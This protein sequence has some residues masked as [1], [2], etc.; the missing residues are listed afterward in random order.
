ME[1][2]KRKIWKARTLCGRPRVMQKQSVFGKELDVSRG[3]CLRAR[4]S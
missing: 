2:G 1:K 4:G 3:L